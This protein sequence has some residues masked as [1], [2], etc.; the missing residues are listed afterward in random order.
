MRSPLVLGALLACAWNA[1]AHTPPDLPAD[2]SIDQLRAWVDQHVHKRSY[3][4]TS[5]DTRRLMLFEPTTL[6]K[7]PNG[8]V[9][10]WFRTELFQPVVV[11]GKTVR[12]VR[13]KLEVDCRELRYK[14]VVEELYGAPNMGGPAHVVTPPDTWGKPR[15]PNSTSGISMRR[16]CDA[17]DANAAAS[18]KAAGTT[19]TYVDRL[20][21]TQVVQD[22]AL[23]RDAGRWEQLQSAYTADGT[24][25]TSWF[26]GSAGEFVRRS[27]ESARAG[28]R[29]QHFMGATSIELRGDRAIAE[30]RFILL[31]R[32]SLQGAQVDVTS[33]G[34]FYDFFVRDGLH[35]RIKRRVPIYERDRLDPVDPS[36]S[37][38][39]DAAELARYPDA[40][41]HVAYL[42]ASRGVAVTPG[43]PTPN[44]EALTRLY[45]EG[46][47]WLAGKDKSP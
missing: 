28:S 10:G 21:I 20:A 27:M 43:L 47:A 29:S 1:A 19:Q 13:K 22:W 46:E 8:N 12:S 30:S 36:A 34:R 26:A 3:V 45:G 35:W 37:V 17:A 15:E 7:L 18:A 44:S 14:E 40:Y 42:Q 39:L 16:A 5:L 38:K 11:Q 4:E 6:E 23:A 31:L 2:A 9:V 24:M 25:T 33:Y 32:G 41:R